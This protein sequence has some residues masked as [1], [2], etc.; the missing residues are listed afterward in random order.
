MCARLLVRKNENVY[1]CVCV[2]VCVCVC[3]REREREREREKDDFSL[4]RSKLSRMR[5]KTHKETKNHVLRGLFSSAA[6]ML[7]QLFKTAAEPFALA[8]R[9]LIVV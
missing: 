8:N 4:E 9:A 7:R 3:E 2:C 6:T 1:M 5:P